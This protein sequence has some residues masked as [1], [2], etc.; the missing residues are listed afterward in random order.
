MIISASRR[1]DI[2]AFYPEWI[3]NRLKAGE[4]LV[5]NPMRETQVARI[6]LDP[7]LIECIVFWTKNPE[8]MLKYLDD[9]TGMGYMY[10][11]TY[12][13][14]YYGKEIEPHL[15][16]VADRIKTFIELSNKI[17]KKRVIWRYD[18]IVFTPDYSPE[19]HIKCFDT[20]ARIL[21]PHTEKA[22]VSFVDIYPGKNYAK[23]NPLGMYEADY[24]TKLEVMKAFAEIAHRENIGIATCAENMD[25]LRKFG[26]EKNSCIDARLIERLIGEQIMD[27]PEKQRSA[28]GCARSVDIG[29]YDTC[30]HGCAYCYANIDMKKTK[31]IMS[32]YDP[33]SPL[34]CGAVDPERDQVYNRDIEPLIVP[35]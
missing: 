5:R 10:Y 4:V 14:N 9:I 8:P 20:L 27:E 2:P 6:A 3:A 13:L 35:F 24:G 32:A 12:T 17:G 23:L 16:D 33:A 21:G 25:E 19:W 28:C 7:K 29:R 30:P 18:P 31:D 22:V 11:F 15:P 34:L 26:I 1:T